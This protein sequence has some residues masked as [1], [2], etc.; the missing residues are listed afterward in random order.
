MDTEI[1]ALDHENPEFDRDYGQ[2]INW[3]HYEVDRATLVRELVEY[4]HKNGAADRADKIAGADLSTSGAIAYCLN[5]GA[6]LKPSSRERLDAWLQNL[7]TGIKQENNMNWDYIALTAAGKN[8]VAYVNA[9]SQIDNLKTRFLAG[10]LNRNT[11]IL[12][13]IFS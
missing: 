2:V 13:V 12:G 6:R 1:A 7:E 8:T 11:M 5:R 3:I 4:A 9:Y 10:K